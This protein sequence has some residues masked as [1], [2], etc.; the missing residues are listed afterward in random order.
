MSAAPRPKAGW[1]AQNYDKLLLVIALVALFASALF[2][3][4]RIGSA[5]RDLAEARWERPVEEKSVAPV[6]LQSFTDY[7]EKIKNPYQSG[8]YTNEMMVSELRVWSINPENIPAPIP[9]N[10]IVCPFT[11]HPQPPVVPPEKRDTD[12][13]G[14]PNLAETNLGLDP[15]DP[16]DAYADKDADGFANIE[17][18]QSGTDINDPA[19]FPEVI[20][21]LR[22]ARTVNIPFVLRFQG[23]NEL[24]DGL[25]FLLNLRTLERSYFVKIGDEVEGFTVVNYTPDGVDGPT[26]TLQKGDTKVDLVKGRQVQKDELVALL[27]FLLDN[28]RYKVKVGDPVSLKGKEYKVIDIKRNAV[29]IRDIETRRSSTIGPIT[30]EEK[31]K[32]LGSREDQLLGGVPFTGPPSNSPR[33]VT[34]TFDDSLTP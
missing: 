5:R 34:P 10:A 18:F 24:P 29:S 2:L 16:A 14:I 7:I 17:E 1:I 3:V 13:D 26:L 11:Q 28:S 32:L 20:A 33:D 27:V 23:V 31:M 22:L 8:I 19:K 30:E 25:R 6:D 21:K 15:M 4:W 9:Y 12:G